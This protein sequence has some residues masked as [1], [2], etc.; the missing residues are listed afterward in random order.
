MLI[1]LQ[2]IGWKA[3]ESVRGTKFERT[4]ICLVIVTTCNFF[5]N[6]HS[7]HNSFHWNFIFPL[8]VCVCRL[9][10]KHKHAQCSREREIERWSRDSRNQAKQKWKKI[11]K[12]SRRLTF[13]APLHQ[14]PSCRWLVE[15][16][17]DKNLF[18]I[19]SLNLNVLSQ[20]AISEFYCASI[21]KWVFLQNLSSENE[22]ICIKLNLQA[23]HIDWKGFTRRP[24]L[25]PR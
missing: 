10:L 14:T 8:F 3:N 18:Q 23:Q 9:L 12:R 24:V 5:V 2:T 1:S 4:P 22:L 17:T 15:F 16:L 20:S 13:L 19:L 6:F 7:L 25:T 21:S 11:K